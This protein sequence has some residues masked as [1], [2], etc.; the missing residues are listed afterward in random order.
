MDIIIGSIY[1]F[2]KSFSFFAITLSFFSGFFLSNWNHI[3]IGLFLISDIITNATLKTIFKFLMS[4]SDFPII[5]KGTRPY[6]NKECG[7]FTYK[8]NH[9]SKSYGMPSGHSQS[10]SFISTLIALHTK[11]Y[12]KT[13]L[14]FLLTCTAMYMRVYVEKCHTIQQT[15][16]GAFI[17]VSLA[18]ILSYYFGNPFD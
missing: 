2:F 8:N 15:I 12:L 17:G 11:D 3:L 16:V 14:L 4:N 13:I 6:K 7:F 1:T 9:F 18:F 5:G 10:F